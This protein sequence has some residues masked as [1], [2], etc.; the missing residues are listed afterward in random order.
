MFKQVLE[1][2]KYLE[3]MGVAHRDIKTEN[4]LLNKYLQVKVIDF[5]R[6]VKVD[7]N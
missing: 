7:S 2:V 1:A 3:S 4:V 6:S 5:G